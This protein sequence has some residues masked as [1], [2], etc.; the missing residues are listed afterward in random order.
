[1]SKV[2]GLGSL[3][4]LP[5]VTPTSLNQITE[6][7]ITHCYHRRP[8][9]VRPPHSGPCLTLQVLLFLWPYPPATLDFPLLYLC[10]YWFFTW[11]A[12]PLVPTHSQWSPFKQIQILHPEATQIPLEYSS[13]PTVLSQLFVSST[14]LQ[15]V[16]INVTWWKYTVH[17]SSP[18]DGESLKDGDDVSLMVTTHT[19]PDTQNCP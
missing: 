12:P 9:F 6:L 15:Q 17:W 14:P 13:P 2:L 4:C 10:S 8:S 19:G 7:I 3:P 11:N 18:G 5:P 16:A 1:M